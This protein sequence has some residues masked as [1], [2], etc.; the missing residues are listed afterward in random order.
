M[1]DRPHYLPGGDARGIRLAEITTRIVQVLWVPRRFLG[2][3]LK[4]Q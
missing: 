2:G 1:T 4:M 3:F